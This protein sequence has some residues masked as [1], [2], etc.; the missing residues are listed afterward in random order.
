M[1]QAISK[2]TEAKL[3]VKDPPSRRG[4]Y[5]NPYPNCLQPTTLVVVATEL[6]CIFNIYL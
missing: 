5:L 6:S 1:G 3:K 4:W 2:A